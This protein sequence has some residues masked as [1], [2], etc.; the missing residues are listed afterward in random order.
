MNCWG[1][2][3][4]NPILSYNKKSNKDEVTNTEKF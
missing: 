3:Y 2:G 1:L 4:N